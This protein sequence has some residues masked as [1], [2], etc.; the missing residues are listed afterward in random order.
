MIQEFIKKL[1]D[2]KVNDPKMLSRVNNFNLLIE[3]LNELD[4]MIGMKAFKADVIYMIK[5]YLVSNYNDNNRNHSVISGAPG[6][7]KTTLA[8]IVAKIYVSLGMINRT[9]RSVTQVITE[10]NY[11]INPFISGLLF[12]LVVSFI[13]K[14]S[15][16]IGICILI[17]GICTVLFS[18]T[19]NKKN[20][21]ISENANDDDYFVMLSREDLVSKYV[22]GTAPQAKTALSKCVG[23]VVFIDEAYKLV[24]H[25]TDFDQYGGEAL[26][27]L[28]EWMDEY[29]GRCLVIFGG[30][31]D[32]M[33]ATIFRSQPGLKRRC[34]KIYH[35]D[36][37]TSD[38]IFEIFKLQLDKKSM[39][40]SELASEVN[41]IRTLFFKNH[42]LFPYS[43][44]DT[45]RLVDYIEQYYNSQ[46]F[47]SR[48]S[49]T[50]PQEYID[51]SLVDM[52]MYQ[53]A[54]AQRSEIP[55][56]KSLLDEF[57]NL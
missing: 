46:V 52:G 48:A 40:L 17:V 28:I 53:L 36:P 14:P 43:G 42:N 20:K 15:W 7:G 24:G 10:V 30:Y 50:E 1:N 23:K 27:V 31:E 19:T 4:K 8:K 38:E 13:F 26:N 3:G 41:D 9:G 11:E 39:Q 29:R 54:T 34:Q 2:M 21:V 37:Y 51:K 44:G 32:E 56:K 22:G 35:I 16:Y 18:K 12:I 47:D 45:E 49:G 25:R 57:L 33:N 55:K 5:N 6:C